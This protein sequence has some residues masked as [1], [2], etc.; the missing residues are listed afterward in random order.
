[1][2]TI[3]FSGNHF[4]E[5]TPFLL[6][7]TVSLSG[8]PFLYV[9]AIPLRESRFVSWIAFILMEEIHF[10]A[11]PSFSRKTFRLVQAVPFSRNQSF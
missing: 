6:V 10:R 2:E 3:P 1:M 9:K 11:S 4:I 5:W 8:K 7:E